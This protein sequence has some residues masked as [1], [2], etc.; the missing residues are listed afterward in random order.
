MTGARARVQVRPAR[1]AESGTV[2]PTQQQVGLRGECELL[3]HH[4][5]DVYAGGP[6]GERIEIGIV[7]GV[8]IGGEHRGGHV[9]VHVVQHLGQAAAALPPDDAMDAP[10]PEVLSVAGGLQLA[11][12]R[13]R[14]TR[15]SSSPSNAGS[16]GSSPLGPDGPSL[17]VPDVHSQHSRLK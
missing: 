7:G 13:H 2:F 17:E 10:P 3:A 16:S 6:L 9:D 14:S 4:F 8:G 5:G 15:P 1:G 11:G 12:D